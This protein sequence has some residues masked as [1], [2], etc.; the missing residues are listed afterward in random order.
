[1]YISLGCYIFFFC[2]INIDIQIFIF[3]FLPAGFN[4]AISEDD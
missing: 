3:L 2:K 1:M 4:N